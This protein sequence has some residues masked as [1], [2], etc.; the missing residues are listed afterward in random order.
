MT[1]R[2]ERIG[3]ASL[4]IGGALAAACSSDD[5]LIVED[6]DDEICGLMRTDGQRYCIDVYEASR[7]DASD[8]DPGIDDNGR[9]RSLPDRLPW[10]NV[11]WRAARGACEARN[12]RL[13]EVDE[14]IDA[15]DGTTGTGGTVYAYG[16]ALDA[17]LCN[18]DG[19]GV[20]ISGSKNACV[21]S[22]G[23]LDQSGNVWEWVGNTIS[24]ASARGGGFRSSQTH[25]C[26][27]VRPAIMATEIDIDLG[28]R[29]CRSI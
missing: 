7:V 18:L 23:T 2:I 29:C 4:L 22:T 6:N 11:T 17:T 12:A 25:R 19:G 20:V 3:L 21:A 13:C 16:D 14:W 1:R 5:P 28:F 10:I 27:D 26:V 8:A 9:A 15:C 24:T